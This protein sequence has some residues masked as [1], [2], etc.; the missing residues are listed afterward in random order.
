MATE[1][2][3]RA[4]ALAV[5]GLLGA[6]GCASG[7]VAP[8]VPP[9]GSLFTMHAAPLDTNFDATPI[10][11]KQGTAM[12]H[13]FQEP[14]SGYR[15]PILTWGDAS[16]QAAAAEA[17]IQRIHYVDYRLLSVLGIYVQLTVQVSGD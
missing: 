2:R 3:R 12:V 6:L 5:A 15:I 8:V 17:R 14:I 4:T 7:V 10:G 1:R 16:V 9:Y 11:S 13:Y